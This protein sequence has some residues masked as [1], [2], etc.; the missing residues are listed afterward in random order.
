VRDALKRS[1]FETV[2]GPLE[3]GQTVDAIV[4]AWQSAGTGWDA[5]R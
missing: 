4:T 3:S 2:H 5:R 1:G